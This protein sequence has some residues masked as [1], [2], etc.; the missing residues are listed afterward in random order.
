MAWRIWK[1]E[2]RTPRRTIYK[3]SMLSTILLLACLLI[4]TIT[5]VRFGK[6]YNWTTYSGVLLALLFNLVATVVCLFGSQS[7]EEGASWHG[8]IGITHSLI[9]FFACG[10]L[11]LVCYVF[12]PREVGGGDV[13]L[14][15][16]TGAFVGVY[17][18]FEVLLWTFILTA[19]FVIVLFIWQHGALQVLGR[20]LRFVL[21]WI[22]LGG[23]FPLTDEDRKPLKKR[24]FLAPFALLAVVIVQFKLINWL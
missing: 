9:G 1:A 17:H 20:C 5:D 14:I 21:Y 7:L 3:T 24:K 18:G 19:C 22:R 6:I 16:M 4:A 23:M 12:F 13:K 11:M 8:A 15:A 2:H 10:M